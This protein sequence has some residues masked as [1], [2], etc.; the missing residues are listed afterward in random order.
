MNGAKAL[1]VFSSFLFSIAVMHAEEEEEERFARRVR[2]HLIIN[3]SPS[4]VEEALRSLLMYPHSSFLQASY[5]SAL[6][7]FGDERKMIEAWESYVMQFPDKELDRELIEVMAWGILQK[8]AHSSSIIMRQ[9]ALLAALFSQDA[10]GVV[11]L[12]NAMH[13]SNYAVRAVAVKM[14]SHFRDQKLIDEVKRLFKEER[15]WIVRQEVIKAVGKMKIKELRSGLESFIASDERH[16][17][18][19]ALAIT[20]L[21]ELFDAIEP[22]NIVQLTKSKRAGLRQ[23]V[24]Q[25]IAHFNYTPGIDSLLA[26]SQDSNCDV[27]IAAWQALG[28]MNRAEVQDIV[29]VY[30]VQEFNYK[31]AISAAWVLM[32]HSSEKGEEIMRKYINSPQRQ[33]RL[34]AAS[35]LAMTAPYGMPLILEQFHTHEDPMVRLNLALGMI[36]QRQSTF[37]ATECIRDL[38]AANQEPWSTT[39]V[40]IFRIISNQHIKNKEEQHAAPEVENQLIRLELLN[41]LA[42]LKAPGTQEAIRSYLRD[43]STEISAL[44]AA[45]LLSE[46]DASAILL[47][48]Q[49]L[50]DPQ[51]KI[52]LQA[53]L[54]LSMWSREESAIQTLEE[55]YTKSGS[56]LK[57]R[58]VE[59][60]GRIGSVRSVP[61]LL[62][63]IKEPSQTLRLI[64]AIALIQCLNH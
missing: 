8:A 13:D 1:L 64:A 59:G 40:G 17:I 31:V 63:V 34:L 15:V 57:A 14:S 19:K 28:Q 2:A 60:I 61:F 53:A 7:R 4:A 48:Q 12:R 56:E 45:S 36:G 51:A 6:A 55:E 30:E 43:S 27:R 3:D 33:E 52:R 26:L 25:A 11:I 29:A 41:L 24:C 44:A 46:G 35:A 16:M 22:L 18:E 20:S 47:V 23:L 32:L 39:E 42:M 50:T 10:K 21:L 38:L 49:L 9:M 5:I 54:I 37:L 58:I 62:T